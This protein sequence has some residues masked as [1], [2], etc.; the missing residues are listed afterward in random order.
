MTD[1][2]LAFREELCRLLEG[3]EDLEVVVKTVDGQETVSLAKELMP[4]VAIIDMAMPR[5]ESIKAT[6]QV[7]EAYPKTAILMV[8][9]YDYESYI[10]ASLRAGAAGYLPGFI[11]EAFDFIRCTGQT[12]TTIN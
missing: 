9:A 6:R 1:D 2:H 3:E 5:L 10:L 11:T 8:S 7:K 12:E 4:D